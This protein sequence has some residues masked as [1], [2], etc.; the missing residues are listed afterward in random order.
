MAD[1]LDVINP[2]WLIIDIGMK[3]LARLLDSKGRMY[4]PHIL[5]LTINVNNGNYILRNI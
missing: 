2:F 5:E 4:M 1:D 3:E